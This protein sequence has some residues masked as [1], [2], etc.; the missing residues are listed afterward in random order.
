MRT[1]TLRAILAAASIGALPT[2]LAAQ[3][4]D[5]THAASQTHTVARGET[6]WALAQQFLANPFRWPEIYN[7]NKTLIANPHWI[8]PGEVLQLPGAATITG[9][10]VTVTPPVAVVATPADT[11]AKVDTV[12]HAD[13][14]AKADTAMAAADTAAATRAAA[15]EFAQISRAAGFRRREGPV[16][17][18][19]VAEEAAPPLPTVQIGEYVRAP[20][21]T[22]AGASTGVGRILESGELDPNG[23]IASTS[24]FQPYD[25]VLVTLSGDTAAK[26]GDR[27]VVVSLSD[28]LP[29]LGQIV[30]PTG[31]VELQQRPKGGAAGVATV[32]QLFGQMHPDQLLVPLDTSNV[33]TTKRPGPVE[34]GLWASIKWIEGSPTLPTMQSYAVLDL[35]AAEGVKP[36]DE[37]QVFRRRQTSAT[38]GQADDP[39]IPIGR[40]KA[41]K[42][43]PFGTTALITAQEQPAINVGMMVRVSAKMP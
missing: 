16:A 5:T 8:Y 21:V 18:E 13:T 3:Q 25:K 22:K 7:L 29:G 19:A 43:T 4:P 31:V 9:I 36:G 32:V 33:W 34:D 1:P 14:G 38:E 17:P 10:S 40:A 24:V 20:Y 28:A 23:E 39:E 15:E 42:V 27:Y 35:T 12:A 37:F 30:V 2:A 6:L 26:V 41:I 11:G